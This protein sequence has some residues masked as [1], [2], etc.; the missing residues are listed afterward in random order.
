MEQSLEHPA[1]WEMGGYFYFWGRVLG[2]ASRVAEGIYMPWAPWKV[3][4]VGL[5]WLGKSHWAVLLPSFTEVDSEF[6]ITLQSLQC[7]FMRYLCQ[8]YTN[9]W[10]IQ[11][12]TILRRASLNYFWNLDSPLHPVHIHVT[13]FLESIRQGKYSS[14]KDMFLC[15]N[16]SHFPD[17]HPLLMFSLIFF[18]LLSL[19]LSGRANLAQ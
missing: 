3:P 2:E 13:E 1:G 11:S 10:P 19:S 15:F 8:V 18:Q 16:I 4:G 17:S 5:R 14:V 9:K 12:Y 7:C 6:K